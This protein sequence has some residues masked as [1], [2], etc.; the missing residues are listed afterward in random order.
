VTTTLQLKR[1]RL[2]T[3]L[4][5]VVL[6]A[7]SKGLVSL[8]WED[9]VEPTSRHL[10]RH[11]GTHL[12]QDVTELPG[13]SDNLLAYVQG[14]IHSL[15]RLPVDPPGTAFQRTVWAALV[16]IPVGNT[17]SYA[18]LASAIGKPTA[19]RAVANANAN[20]PVPIV[21]PCHRVIASGGGLGGFSCGL[22]RKRWLLGHEGILTD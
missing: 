5:E 20:N 18:Q 10:S 16:T 22:Y 12:V 17:W 9:R 7:S 2:Q 3:P 6:M 11:L 15:M 8:Q 1:C 19:T 13:L 14:D 4:G 21:I